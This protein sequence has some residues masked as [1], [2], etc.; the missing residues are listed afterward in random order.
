MSEYGSE[1]KIVY[2]NGG[3]EE[4]LPEPQEDI[5]SPED[6]GEEHRADELAMSEELQPIRQD[7]DLD[8]LEG[9]AER[10][11]PTDTFS[12][13][14]SD[15]MTTAELLSI[16]PLYFRLNLFLKSDEGENVANLLKKVCNQL[17]I[18]NNNFDKF[19]GAS[20]PKE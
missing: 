7:E 2:I 10:E 3:E 11:K 16:D 17:E 15:S 1:K 8:E 14:S 5:G 9:G 13:S 4:P 6:F 12:D 20:R 18:L 19:M